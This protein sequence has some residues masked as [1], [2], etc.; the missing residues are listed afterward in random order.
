MDL[1][2]SQP[3]P[4]CLDDINLGLR[5]R[6]APTTHALTTTNYLPHTR[7]QSLKVSRPFSTGSERVCGA[8]SSMDRE[9]PAM[10]RYFDRQRPITCI[11]PRS[12]TVAGLLVPVAS[13]HL[14]S[15]TTLSFVLRILIV[16]LGQTTP[17]PRSHRRRRTGAIRARP[18]LQGPPARPHST[19][20]LISQ[21]GSLTSL[22]LS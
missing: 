13:S 18:P 22:T 7:N 6:V 11:V 15:T 9:S 4:A 14:P 1:G 5:S 10:R 12:A 19:H 16:M 3:F 20:R 17:C 21:F 2:F 8:W